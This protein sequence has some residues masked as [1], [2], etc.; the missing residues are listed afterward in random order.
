MILIFSAPSGAGKSTL[1]NF[2]LTQRRDLEF[3]IS[4]TTRDPRGVEQHGKEYYFITNPEFERLIRD[5]Q[6]VEW[7]QVY[8]GTYYGT[9]KSE[10][11]RIESAGHHVVFDVDVEGGINLKR[12]FGD[13]ARSIFVA[14]PSVAEL[15]K[16]L[17]NRATDAPEKIEERVA[18]ASSEMEK[19]SYFD[20]VIVN[21]NLEKAKMELLNEVSTFLAEE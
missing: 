3:S 13:N 16:R 10:I 5:D 21:D 20:T 9:L 7:Q 2:L 1:I 19:A 14:P 4:A 15:R 12:I 11:E 8:S 18:K 17:I 6:L